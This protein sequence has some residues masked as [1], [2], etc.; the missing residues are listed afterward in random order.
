M[1]TVAGALNLMVRGSVAEFRTDLQ[2][3]A[4][5]ARAKGQDIKYAM[6][7]AADAGTQGF[8]ALA[9]NI[10]VLTQPVT[11]LTT[12]LGSMGGALGLGAAVTAVGG[13]FTASA[14]MASGMADLS[15]KTGV[16][17]EQLSRFST[18]AKLSSTSMDTVAE[19]MKK[20]S[21]N[22]VEA[23]NGNEKLERVWNA[24]GIDTKS[25][26]DLA[27]DEIMVK[28]GQAIQGLD[29]KVVQDVVKTLG[30]KGG[31]EALVFLNELNQRLGETKVKISTEFAQGAKEFEDNLI[32]L[33]SR[34][35][36]LANTLTA[37]LLPAING[38]LSQMVK[39]GGF[40]ENLAPA[41]SVD[42]KGD[43]SKQLQD[44]RAQMANLEL[45]RRE[46]DD[47]GVWEDDIKRVQNR[48]SIIKSQMEFMDSLKPKALD[49]TKTSAV[50]SAI[51]K[52]NAGSADKSGD[53]F[54]KGLQERITKAG[55]GEIAMLRLQAAEKGVAS[56]AEPLIEKLI[57]QQGL[58]AA[59]QYA[60]NLDLST[61]SLEFQSSLV[62]KTAQ[63][64]EVLNVQHSREVEFQKIKIDLIRQYGEMA[65]EAESKMSA[66]MEEAT[67]KQIALIKA[68]QEAERTF[69]FGANKTFR[70]FADDASNYGKLAE[71]M[72]TN[73]VNNMADAMANFATTGK[74]S[75]TNLANGI[76]SDIIRIQARAAMAGLGSSLSGLFAGDMVTNTPYT[77]TEP[78]GTTTPLPSANGN[79]FSNGSVIPFA[80]GGV[81]SRPT[82]F[83]M[84]SGT[85]LMGEAGPE[86]ILPLAR[87]ANGKLGVQSIGG[88]KGGDVV[89]N[90]INNSSQAQAT[91]TSKTDAMGNRQIEIMVADMV[92]KAISTGRTD[93][94]MRNAYNIRRSGK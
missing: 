36:A 65:P 76:I 67:T 53:N 62:G 69:S 2:Q 32:I 68:R 48:I 28:F 54:L 25:L 17:V 61:Q 21:I 3:M 82:L 81:V 66:A 87:A 35:S 47:P 14:N 45:K 27:P 20:L 51:S 33:N 79:V 42:F 86:G 30:G 19:L 44:S 11:A 57:T 93:A 13:M 74:L 80:N 73:S 15:V 72:L 58:K 6:L 91:A 26:K 29:P 40:L 64:Q 7:G 23:A 92:N 60:K 84:A 4:E 83:P 22:A 38:V 50:E 37:S 43:L 70:Q 1:A 90:V 89:I 49:P 9:N 46:S 56:Q 77:T 8:K 71:N 10:G 41:M 39:G 12:A 34:A 31:S 5:I 63:E 16:S 94:A 52:N 24:I 75:F 59:D 78:L 85:G 55:E 18:V 88:G